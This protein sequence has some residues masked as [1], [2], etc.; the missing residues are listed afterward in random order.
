MFV[1]NVAHGQG[2]GLMGHTG[3]N[4]T[5]LWTTGQSQGFLPWARSSDFCIIFNPGHW[6]EIR[7]RFGSLKLQLGRDDDLRPWWVVCAHC[8]VNCLGVG[9]EVLA[10][11]VST[12]H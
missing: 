6:L 12:V 3:F 4:Y 10:Q 2:Q 7:S 11:V 9:Q 1:T 8:A 5:K